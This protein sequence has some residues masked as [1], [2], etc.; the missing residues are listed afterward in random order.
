L[1]QGLGASLRH[2]G[3]L[4]A[5]MS[6]VQ[7]PAALLLVASLPIG[8]QHFRLLPGYELGQV[9]GPAGNLACAV[10]ESGLRSWA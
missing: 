8:G 4:A 1:G 2:V 6:M 10:Q 9:D 5:A 3:I 7:T